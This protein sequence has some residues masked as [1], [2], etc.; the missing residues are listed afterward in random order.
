MFSLPSSAADMTYA[1][2]AELLDKGIRPD[3][4]TARYVQ[5]GIERENSPY[6]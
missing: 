4:V 5:H 6:I 2:E 3:L 1:A